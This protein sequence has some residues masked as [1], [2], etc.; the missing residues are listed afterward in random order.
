MERMSNPDIRTGAA[1]GLRQG[2]DSQ[3][4]PIVLQA[5]VR[6]HQMRQTGVMKLSR[7]AG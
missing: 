4:G 6:C 5:Q 1:Q 3:L 2:R 7:Q